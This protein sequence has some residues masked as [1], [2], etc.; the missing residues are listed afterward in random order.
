MLLW[1]IHDIPAYG[2]VSGCSVHGYFGCPICGEETWSNW[3]VKSKKMC[4]HTHHK[5]LPR[6]HKFREDRT[7]FL[8]N[9]IENMPPPRR[10]SG[11]EIK[12]KA[13]NFSCSFKGK[14]PKFIL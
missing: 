7:N 2:T 5:F 14:N 3:L 1:A 13:M 11:T 10:L 4:Y 9:E 8:P 12:N 6:D